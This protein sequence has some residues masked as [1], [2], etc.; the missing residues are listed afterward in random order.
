[1]SYGWVVP[2]VTQLRITWNACPSPAASSMSASTLYDIGSSAVQ[3]NVSCRV[4]YGSTV[5][6]DPDW[7]NPAGGS[8][9]DPDTSR[10]VFMVTASLTRSRSDGCT[11]TKIRSGRTPYTRSIDDHTV[12][13]SVNVKPVIFENRFSRPAFCTS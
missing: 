8:C 12:R 1:M 6:N 5:L 4:R 10:K 3:K 7:Q 13:P 9:S 2:S 11:S